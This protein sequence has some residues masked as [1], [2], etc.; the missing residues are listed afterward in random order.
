MSSLAIYHLLFALVASASVSNTV[1]N[2]HVSMTANFNSV[3]LIFEIAEFVHDHHLSNKQ[4]FEFVD[5]FI[6]YYHSQCTLNADDVEACPSQ[7][8]IYEWAIAAFGKHGIIGQT[9]IESLEFALSLHHYTPRTAMFEQLYQQSID[10][11]VERCE[12]VVI[13]NG[14]R[15]PRILQID[16][17]DTSESIKEISDALNA[18]KNESD[19]CTN[20]NWQIFKSHDHW[21]GSSCFEQ[22]EADSNVLVVY[23]GDYLS[24]SFSAIF[25]Y[26]SSLRTL[27]FVLRPISLK[28]SLTAFNLQ[29]YGVELAIK[30]MEYSVI[31]DR[32]VQNVQLQVGTDGN[33]QRYA[34]ESN[35]IFDE[36]LN[37]LHSLLDSE[38]LP[39]LSEMEEEQ[40]KNFMNSID[41]Q[42]T[43]ALLV[44]FD[45]FDQNSNK[46]LSIFREFS[47]NIP[48]YVQIL[49]HMKK[50]SFLYLVPYLE[51]MQRFQPEG[52]QTFSLN[53]INLAVAD[54]D[55]FNFYNTLHKEAKFVDAIHEI[56]D[57]APNNKLI[58]K[59]LATPIEISQS[60]KPKMGG[61]MMGMFGLSAKSNLKEEDVR[62]DMRESAFL[63]RYKSENEI[64]QKRKVITW[65]NNI[66][67]DKKYKNYYRDLQALKSFM[68]MQ[69]I[70]P[71]QKNMYNAIAI[72]D[73]INFDSFSIFAA[74]QDGVA[75]GLPLHFGFILHPNLTQLDEHKRFISKRI[76]QC[77]VWLLNN[78]KSSSKQ[79]SVFLN[80]LYSPIMEEVQRRREK[81]M[82][83]TMAQMQREENENA[84][85]EDLGS[86]LLPTERDI[87]DAFLEFVVVDK[88]QKDQTKQSVL[89]DVYS[90]DISEYLQL[91]SAF[92]EDKGITSLLEPNEHGVVGCL[93]GLNG[94]IFPHIS[95][96]FSV[97]T[98]IGI[99]MEEQRSYLMSYSMGKISKRT[100]FNNFVYEKAD[101][102]PRFS[103]FLS[104]LNNKNLPKEIQTND[105]ESDKVSNDT[106]TVL[107]PKQLGNADEHI[108]DTMYWDTIF[109]ASSDRDT[110]VITAW[111]V[112]DMQSVIG[113]FLLSSF[114][115]I[116]GKFVK[117][118]ADAKGD[119][120]K[121]KIRPFGLRFGVLIN[122]ESDQIS[123]ECA[124]VIC[125]FCW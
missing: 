79:S 118:A 77:V 40:R 121:E 93:L 12:L 99:M 22:M 87:E 92:L 16:G 54:F 116:N 19:N 14:Q 56:M 60:S 58:R 53:G 91:T 88:S 29:G 73:P 107:H 101:V 49:S 28:Q 13:Q 18:L 24:H 115:Q 67:R 33:V 51:T 35:D 94:R 117:Y 70:V 5:A 122:S 42:A 110:H 41:I 80:N 89:N 2:V 106:L 74:I 3:P 1:S 11:M 32:N 100:N 120:G 50:E 69:Q 31:D 47:S 85:V 75:Q 114:S 66:E 48:R 20:C 23:Y 36:T 30:N 103:R 125:I 27:C 112:V 97:Y 84:V 45:H 59:L 82:E 65:M 95:G 124:D 81:Q 4:Y 123:K 37:F 6:D 113:R 52:L 104:W 38:A 63:K 68:A 7:Q 43:K 86:D 62:I 39:N 78:S 34:H 105:A 96:V 21:I 44:A 109:S 61:G 119:D 64:A 111:L 57:D 10:S 90:V 46:F 72:F 83:A 15:S 102:L 17:S 98:L 9:A 26:L 76:M 71:I 8:R 108:V 55:I 25:K